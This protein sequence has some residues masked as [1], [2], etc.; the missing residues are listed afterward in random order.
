MSVAGRGIIVV[1]G[2]TGLQGG[3]VSRQL[4]REGWH[5]RGLTRNAASKRARALA[6][7]GAEVV[8]GDMDDIATLLPL[9]AG[10]YGVYSVQNP[11]IAGPAAE[12]RQGKHV[13]DAAGSSGVRHFVY[14]SAGIGSSGTGVLPWETKVQIEAHIRALG[15]PATILRPLAFMELMTEKK[16]A[17]A[18]AAWSVMPA[19]LGPTRSVG[20]ICADDLGAVAAKVFD[21]PQQFV[22]A[23]IALASDVQSLEQCRV[24]YREV[25]G[26]N[27]PQI[28]LPAWLFK[29]FGFVGQDLTTMWRWLRTETIPLDT[30]PTRAIHPSALTVRAWLRSKS[31]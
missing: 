6:A 25:M 11:I 16:F 10:A 31:L 30:G 22:G 26:R 24:I 15:L 20:W 27:P 9:F 14:G 1:T 5:V 21:A 8:Q 4:L 3:A 29:R 28:P 13:A 18:I 2:A 19:L 7:A 23:E 17:P 12:V